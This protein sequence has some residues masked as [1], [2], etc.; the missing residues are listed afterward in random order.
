MRRAHGS[1][2]CVSEGV[3]HERTHILMNQFNQ[4][5][6]RLEGKG[7]GTSDQLREHP[8]IRSIENTARMDNY[9]GPDPLRHFIER[10][11]KRAMERPN[12]NGPY[13]LRRIYPSGHPDPLVF[14]KVRY[15]YDLKKDFTVP[16]KFELE[17]KGPV[18]ADSGICLSIQV[19]ALGQS[20]LPYQKIDLQDFEMR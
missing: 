2:P 7:M 3:K 10:S 1:G 11:A 18:G 13:Q 12:Q 4:L 6:E 20:G 19:E 16:D 9:N 5:L 14:V 17:V 8:L 15:D